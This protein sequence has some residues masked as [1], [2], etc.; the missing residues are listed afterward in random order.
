MFEFLDTTLSMGWGVVL[1]FQGGSVICKILTFHAWATDDHFFER[2]LDG[3][4]ETTTA[5]RRL[6]ANS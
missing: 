1:Q 6:M 4:V 3:D 5:Y 2:L